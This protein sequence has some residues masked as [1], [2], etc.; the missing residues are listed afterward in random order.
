MMGKPDLGIKVLAT[1][2]ETLKVHVQPSSHG[3]K[4][5]QVILYRKKKWDDLTAAFPFFTI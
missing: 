1:Y 2:E 3:H 4:R 5:K